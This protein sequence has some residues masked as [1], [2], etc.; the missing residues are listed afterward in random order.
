MS[1]SHYCN[2]AS[3]L[4]SKCDIRHTGQVLRCVDRRNRYQGILIL[5]SLPSL[6]PI[7]V[8]RPAFYPPPPPVPYDHPP[9]Y[10]YLPPPPLPI[11]T[12]MF[13]CWYM[14]LL[15]LTT[16]HSLS[17]PTPLVTSWYST[18]GGLSFDCT[19]CGDCCKV[20]GDVWMT[21]AEAKDLATS[22][23]LSPA[24]FDMKHTDTAIEPGG[25]RRLT[26]APSCTFLT[27]TNGCAVY[28]GR[29]LQVR[30]GTS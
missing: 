18:A 7:A 10:L 30:W 11:P 6:F 27:P 3:S 4:T 21:S 28:E 24:Q 29:P 20:T 25:Y 5:L 19:S 9:R 16:T 22:V 8:L 12:F 15:L 14:L 2:V 17:L 23:G 26:A 13:H 1:S